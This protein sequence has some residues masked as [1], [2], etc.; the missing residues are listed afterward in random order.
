MTW[1]GSWG[2]QLAHGCS[3]RTR[4][5][6]QLYSKWKNHTISLVVLHFW[7]KVS[8]PSVTKSPPTKCFVFRA[9]PVKIFFC[10]SHRKLSFIDLCETLS[11]ILLLCTSG[12]STS[13]G[14]HQDSLFSGLNKPSSSSPSALEG[15]SSK[16]LS[17]LV[18]FHCTWST[19][20]I[21]YSKGPKLGTI[22]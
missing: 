13:T 16:P 11:H 14:C 6:H 3:D 18:A 2:I 22:L 4:S 19:Q 8:R 17:I 7:D 5:T 10:I 9:L 21:S 12:E 1:G 15:R 20:C